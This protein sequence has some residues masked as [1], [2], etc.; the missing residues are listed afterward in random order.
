MKT[1]T[2]PQQPRL[3]F[4]PHDSVD[5]FAIVDRAVYAPDWHERSLA[6]FDIEA[7]GV[8]P[9]GDRMVTWAFAI[10]APDGE[11]VDKYSGLILPEDFEV[12]DGAAQVHGWTTDKLREHPDAVPLLDALQ[13]IVVLMAK[14]EMVGKPVV[15]YN[16]PFDTTMLLAECER[17][18]YPKP[19]ALL[20]GP[21]VDPLVLDKWTDR[22]RKGSRRLADVAKLYGVELGDDAH[23]AA[24]DAV[25]A[26][27][28]AFAM[29][30]KHDELR[31][32]A[33]VLHKLQQ[34][35]H[36]EQA[37]SLERYFHGKGGKPD[38]V[39]NRHWPIIP[40]PEATT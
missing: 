39:V 22:W 40:A 2:R 20:E 28:L 24:A 15:I 36:A 23:D 11:V 19:R 25:A 3:P 32:D 37:E 33:H 30:D 27:R 18:N 14:A 5:D 9:H 8:D 7:S 38:A 6:S 13:M 10:V 16:A 1:A 17:R 12:P 35:K 26:A 34:R 29:F 31:T 4:H 21:I